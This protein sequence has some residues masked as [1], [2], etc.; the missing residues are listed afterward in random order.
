MSGH[1]GFV[2][3]KVTL[4]QVFSKYFGFSCQFS[5]HQLLQTHNLSSGPATIG[6]VVAY[7]PSGLSLTHPKKKKKRKL[8]EFVTGPLSCLW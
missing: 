1:V 7:V 4:G 8:N 5:F 6:Q 3:D 2:A